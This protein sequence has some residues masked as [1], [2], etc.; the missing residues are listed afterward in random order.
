MEIRGTPVFGQLQGPLYFIFIVY[1]PPPNYY[2][3][4]I[5]PLV[6][7]KPPLCRFHYNRHFIMPIYGG[8]CHSSLKEPTKGQTGWKSKQI[9]DLIDIFL[10]GM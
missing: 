10:L 5:T 8:Q 7:C 6:L 2:Q 4:L 9:N 3:A 1:Q